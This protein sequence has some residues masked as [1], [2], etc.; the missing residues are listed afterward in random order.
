MRSLFALVPILA[1]LPVALAA[2]TFDGEWGVSFGRSATKSGEVTISDGKG[3]W[4][5]YGGGVASKDNPCLNKRFPLVI[6]SVADAE[7]MIDINSNSV[8]K[9]CLAETLVL[10]PGVD[11]TWTGVLGSGVTMTWARK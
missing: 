2:S 1:T 5:V 10:H 9:G 7:V 6:K 3:S 8:L 4:I 11:G